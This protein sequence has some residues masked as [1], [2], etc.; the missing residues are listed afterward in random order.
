M[1]N[2]VFRLFN[3]PTDEVQTNLEKENELLCCKLFDLTDSD[4]QEIDTTL[5]TQRSCKH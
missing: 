1:A 5:A 2:N 3:N 4:I